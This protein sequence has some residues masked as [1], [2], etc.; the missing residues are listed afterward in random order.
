MAGD[1]GLA[2]VAVKAGIAVLAGVAVFTGFTVLA[3]AAVF[4]GV[5][6]I[7]LT[8]G[9]FTLF[10]FAKFLSRTA[11]VGLATVLI[12]LTAAILLTDV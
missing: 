8:S 5:A 1:A 4:A 11:V 3:G 7:G 2:G 6:V 9:F 10:E 12:G